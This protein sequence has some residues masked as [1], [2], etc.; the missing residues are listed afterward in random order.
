MRLTRLVLP[1]VAALVLTSGCSKNTPTTSAPAPGAAPRA[2]GPQSSSPGAKEKEAARDE[3]ALSAKDLAAAYGDPKEFDAKYKGKE[4]IVEGQVIEADAVM[5][6][7]YLVML[8][9]GAPAPANITCKFVEAEQDK[10][11]R[12][13]DNSRV[14]LKG[15][16]AGHK[17]TFANVFLEDARLL[18]VKE[19]PPEPPVEGK[20]IAVTDVDLAKAYDNDDAAADKQYKE[21]VVEVDGT[22]LNATGRDVFLK[23][24][25]D[26]ATF[27]GKQIMCRMAPPAR[28]KAA[29]LTVG[30]RVKIKGACLQGVGGSVLVW[31]GELAEVGPD[32]AVAVGAAQLA[33]EYARDPKAADQKYKG[34]QLLIEGTVAEVTAHKPDALLRRSIVL[35]GD[36]KA[37][38]PL[39]VEAV[40]PNADPRPVAKLAKGQKV[41]LK[42][43]CQG[44]TGDKVTLWFT[45]VIP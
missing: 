44:L 38:K 9:A 10:A 23:G 41:K 20:G 11:S 6:D 5:S 30:Q 37:E 21:K 45:K 4:V 12:V 7:G 34:K 17:D 22:V 2:T 40:M 14:K 1:C 27:K 31:A 25:F 8:L 15:K 42:G 33:Q 13:P 24:A 29:L 36:P 28:E 35:E 16:C 3:P 43:E 19:P 39:P 18:S 26:S 32:P